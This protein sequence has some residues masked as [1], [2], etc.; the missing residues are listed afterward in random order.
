MFDV[1]VCFLNFA[2][3]IAL[4]KHIEILLLSN[5]CVIVPGF[6]GFIAHHVDARKDENDG[7]F[8]PPIRTIAFN[9]KLTINDS[10][11]AQSYVEAYD[12]SY[13]EA[14]MR[15][16]DEVRE[17]CQRIETDGNYTFNGIGSI[18]LND[19]G[20]YEFAPCEAGIL[21]PELYGLGSF[22][23][24]TLQEIRAALLEQQKTA[25]TDAIAGGN[26]EIA[27][28]S[29]ESST[30]DKTGVEP[31]VNF[32]FITFWRNLAAACVAVITFLLFP[33][34]LN[35]AQLQKSSIDTRMLDRIMP[36]EITTGQEKV[37]ANMRGKSAEANELQCVGE[38]KTAVRDKIAEETVRQKAANTAFPTENY[39]AI[40]LASHVTKTNAKNYVADL[41]Q[42]GYGDAYLFTRGRHHKVLYGHFANETEAHSVLKRMNSHN[43]FAEAWIT[44]VK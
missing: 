21:T 24:A 22:K 29:G 36:K 17:L 26:T 2:K 42:R 25:Q 37:I 31:A 6:G 40:V 4:D 10:L 34:P 5:D 18:S 41:R 23:P 16:E 12:I 13:P 9:P 7:S 15:I 39:Y 28:K 44:F 30:I 14:T 19:E 35:N 38:E 8:L 33:S 20:N 1:S 32:R 27:P 3:V 11:L 43:E